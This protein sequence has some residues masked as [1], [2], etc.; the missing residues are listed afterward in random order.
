MIKYFKNNNVLLSILILSLFNGIILLAPSIFLLLIYNKILTFQNLNSLLALSV[1]YLIVLY[2]GYLIENLRSNIASYSGKKFIQKINQFFLESYPRNNQWTAN[3]ISQL[4]QF[5]QSTYVFYHFEIFFGLVYVIFLYL[6]EP[7]LAL[8]AFLSM[9]LL[10]I[11]TKNKSNIQTPSAN[12][13][14]VFQSWSFFHAVGL[15]NLLIPNLKNNTSSSYLRPYFLRNKLTNQIKYLKFA[16]ISGSLI[17]SSILVINYNLNPGVMFMVLVLMSRIL[18]PA[19]IYGTGYNLI[20]SQE[21]NL[22][23][24]YDDEKFLNHFDKKKNSNNTNIQ[25]NDIKLKDIQLAFDPRNEFVKREI[26]L[27]QGISYLII[28]PNGSGKSTAIQTILGSIPPKKGHVKYDDIAIE[29]FS[30]ENRQQLFNFMPQYPISSPITLGQFLSSTSEWQINSLEPYAK[31]L[32]LLPKI[33]SLPNQWDT[34]LDSILAICSAGEIQKLK[35]IQSTQS[36]KPWNF[37]DEP[38]H[39]LDGLGTQYLFRHFQQ[40]KQ[41][42]QS[43]VMVSHKP[44]LMEFFDQIILVEKFNI[45]APLSKEDFI[46]KI[47]IIKK[48]S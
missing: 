31:N 17:I 19:E 5:L 36:V 21:R 47:K 9:V 13:R 42:K 1:L 10:F 33:L 6:F 27:K 32:G 34:P 41:K 14:R 15:K 18:H 25:G 11:V 48:P 12:D 37:F 40:I 26:H 35:L 2:L 7:Y 20:K 29:F 38:E 24:L 43:I 30:A 39:F 4:D 23:L 45:Q 3:Q 28:G 22:K 8:Y 44:S 16:L 46:K